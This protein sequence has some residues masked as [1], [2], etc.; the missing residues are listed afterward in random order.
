MIETHLGK[1]VVRWA[2][3]VGYLISEAELKNT[4]ANGVSIRYELR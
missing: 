3:E 2:I 1:T 4:I